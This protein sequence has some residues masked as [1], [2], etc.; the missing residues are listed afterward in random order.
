MSTSDTIAL[1]SA[2]GTWLA[3]IATI[4]TA[5]ITGV[6]VYVAFKTLHS[7]KDKEKFMQLVRLKRA[8]F[9]YRQKIESITTLN[10]D[11]QK[12]NEH[13]INVLQPALSNVYHEMKLAG[14]KEKECIEFKLFDA[15]WDSQKKYES[16]HMNYAELLNSAVELQ[17]IIKIGF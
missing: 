11:H 3:A 10:H 14:F 6:A 13:V 1:W 7:W 2:V 4:I 17:E 16:S 15:V 5:V 12:I 9:A 8:I